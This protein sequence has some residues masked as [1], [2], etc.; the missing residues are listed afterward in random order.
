MSRIGSLQ[1]MSPGIGVRHRLVRGGVVSISAHAS[2]DE[3]EPDTSGVAA[4]QASDPG[5]ALPEVS[6]SGPDRVGRPVDSGD[7]IRD[8][9]RCL[10]PIPGDPCRIARSA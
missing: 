2:A 6:G 8:P 5:V 1:D 9:G 4:P 10:T 3:A 7:A